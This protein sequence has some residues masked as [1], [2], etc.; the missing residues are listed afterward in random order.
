MQRINSTE[1]QEQIFSVLALS[2][3]REKAKLLFV[4]RMK[5]RTSEKALIFECLDLYCVLLIFHCF[6]DWG[7]R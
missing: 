1:F 4:H 2:L 6:I 3:R 7:I 5:L